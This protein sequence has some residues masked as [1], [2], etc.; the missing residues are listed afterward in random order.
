MNFEQCSATNNELQMNQ[1]NEA[2]TLP[3]ANNQFW[4]NIKRPYPPSE[5]EKGKRGGEALE[6]INIEDYSPLHVLWDTITDVT[7]RCFRLF[8]WRKSEDF[9]LNKW[10]CRSG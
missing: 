6:K 9:G 8:N 3:I 5:D 1:A 7:K 10:V 4:L 2:L